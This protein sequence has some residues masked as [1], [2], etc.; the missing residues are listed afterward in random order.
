VDLPELNRQSRDLELIACSYKEIRQLEPA[1]R[2]IDQVHK[3]LRAKRTIGEV[4]AGD[5]STT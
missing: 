1:S 2:F 5:E 3:E 4:Q